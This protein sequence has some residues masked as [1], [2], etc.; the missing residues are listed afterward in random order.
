[1][2]LRVPSGVSTLIIGSVTEIAKAFHH[3]SLKWDD[4]MREQQ[5]G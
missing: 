2:T 1:M 5:Q 4:P 3:E